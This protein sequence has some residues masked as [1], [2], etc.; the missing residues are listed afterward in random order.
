MARWTPD[1]SFYPSPRLAMEAPEET[2]GYV[3][4]VEPDQASR[5]DA[6]G[7]D[8]PRARLEHL[9]PDRLDA[10]DGRRRATS[11][12]TSA[13]TR[14]APR[15]AR[16]R[17]DPHVE[18]RYLRRSGTRVVAHVR[19]RHE[20]RSARAED[21]QDD[22]GRRADPQD[23]L[24]AAAHVALRPGRDLHERSRR[25]ER[26]GRGGRHLPARLRHVRAARAVGDRTRPAALPVRLLVAPEPGHARVER[27]GDA[28]DVRA[29]RRAG[30]AARP[31]VRARDARLGPAPRQAP[32]DAR[33]SAT[34]TRW[35]SS[36]GRRTIRGASTGSSASSSRSRTCRP[37][38]GSG[39]ARTATWKIRKVITIPAEPAEAELLPP[40]LQGFGAV[41]PLV[42]RH[43]PVARRP[44]PLRLLLGHRRLPAVRRQRPVRSEGDRPR[45]ARWDRLAR[46]RTRPSARSRRAADGRGESRRPPRLRLQ[47]ALL[48]LGHA[49]LP[50]RPRRLDREAGRLARRRR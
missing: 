5:P 36:C 41:P 20:G 46:A 22:R 1:P 15:S 11:C 23:G 40:L 43:Q 28:G 25:R 39:T 47:L 14:A 24:L 4:L 37:R 16:R 30:E 17:R 10:R 12:T 31:R 29:R 32:A 13:G 33:R 49:V 27:V 50:R 42:T 26:R 3:A 7:V 44:L 8:R 38:S 35:C 19:R 18:R 2:L 45:A 6:L 48:E 9:R 21:R 34:S